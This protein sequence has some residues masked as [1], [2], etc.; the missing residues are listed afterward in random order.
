MYVYTVYA[1]MKK[2]CCCMLFY[3][4]IIIHNN[5]MLSYTLHTLHPPPPQQLPPPTTHTHL[6]DDTNTST[7]L[8]GECVCIAAYAGLFMLAIR[9]Q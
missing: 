5:N 6:R 8:C 7:G 9:G 2:Q 3:N 4:L 1:D